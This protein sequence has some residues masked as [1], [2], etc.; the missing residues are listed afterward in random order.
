M[1]QRP[2]CTSLAGRQTLPEDFADRRQ[3][4]GLYDKAK[5][6]AHDVYETT[7]DVMRHAA[8]VTADKAHQV[9]NA[10]AKKAHELKES[11]KDTLGSAQRKTEQKTQ[12]LRNDAGM[13]I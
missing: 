13:S 3:G 12:E 9:K 2:I 10:T 7:K 1:S 6:K 11:T 4:K 8:D 5:E